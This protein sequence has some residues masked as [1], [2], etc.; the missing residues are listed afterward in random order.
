MKN[1]PRLI[2]LAALIR[3]DWSCK[4]NYNVY[5]DLLYNKWWTPDT[6]GQ[7]NDNGELGWIDR[8]S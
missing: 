5:M 4:Q 8:L 7:T 2:V 6:N 1:A 3:S